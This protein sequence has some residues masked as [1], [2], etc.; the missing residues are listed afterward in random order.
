MAGRTKPHQLN[1]IGTI[2]RGTTGVNRL[3]RSDRW[4]I[5][6]DLVT[7]RLHAATDP[8]VV[9]LGYGASPWTTFEL[10]ARL[11]TVRPDVRVV[12]LEID[13][14]RVVPGRDGVSFT[15]GGFEL[16]GLRPVLVR[17]FNVLRQYPES[18]VPDAWT[19]IL[20]GLAPGGLL[21][22]G[23][24]DELGRRSAWVLLDHAGPL[25]LTLAWD[26]FTVDRPSDIAER[27]PKALIHRNV[28]GE[29]VHALLTAADRAWSHAAPL[30]PFGPRV[31]WRAAAN[32]L[33]EQGFPVR[34]YRRRMRDNVLSV[35]WDVVAPL[36]L[37]E[38][39]LA[40]RT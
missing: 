23:T 31:R 11:R 40:A 12:G 1:P 39:A 26:P 17:A 5:N 27:L 14:E 4:L 37:D 32:I 24:C 21:V 28:P 20:S 36:P 34:D 16:A 7:A 6:D 9:D 13:P 33:R 18:A 30:A 3:R 15:R 35:P 19:T 8:L 25:S 29:G 38:P 2:T 22:D 10:A